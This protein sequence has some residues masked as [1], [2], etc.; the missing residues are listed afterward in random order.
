MIFGVVWFKRDLRLHDHA[1]LADAA[2][3][4][5][6]L[7]LYV[8]EPSLWAQPDAARQHYEFILE[9]LRELARALKALGGRLHVRTGEVTEVLTQL[10]TLAPFG[11]LV[12]HE[13][14]GN[15][16]TF[17]RDKAVA[18]WCRAHGVAWQEF[19]Q[20]G[21]VRRLK[22]RN[23]WLSHWAAHTQAEPEQY[24]QG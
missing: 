1:A 24:P 3:H 15:A 9:S 11:R 18:R 8:I 2:A 23:H 12:S 6:L 7:C 13:E 20:F 22:S 14:T 5:P 10:H 4:G 19:A 21:V 17:E 16:L